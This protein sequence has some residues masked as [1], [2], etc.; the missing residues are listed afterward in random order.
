MGPAEKIKRNREL[1]SPHSIRRGESP[2]QGPY[3]SFNVI[4]DDGTPATLLCR[5]FTNCAA[6]VEITRG[7][8]VA[9]FYSR[10]MADPRESAR[11]DP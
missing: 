7:R 1:I 11:D 8:F 3:L 10:A 5:R 6:Q 4:D 9:R 2:W